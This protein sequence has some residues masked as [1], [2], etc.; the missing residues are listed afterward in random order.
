MVDPRDL[1]MWSMWSATSERCPGRGVAA[2]SPIDRPRTPSGRRGRVPSAP[3]SLGSAGHRPAR[4]RGRRSPAELD[5]HDAAV[6]GQSLE[7]VVGDVAG[8]GRQARAPRVAGDD[9]GL[10][11]PEGV[12]HRLGA[13]RARCRRASPAGSSR[14]RP[15][16]RT[17][18]GPPCSAC[19]WRRRPR[20]GSCCGSASCTGRPG[21]EQ[22]A[23]RPGRPRSQAPLDADQRR[24]LARPSTIRST[25]SAVSRQFEVVGVALDHP[26]DQVD[27]LERRA[28][29]G[30]AVLA[31]G[32]R[33]TR[34]AP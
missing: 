25:S 2:S 9:R 4:P 18:R 8:D 1:A 14:G 20:R 3:H 13:R 24:D 21:V 32:C 6:R 15:A 27:L 28:C 12:G 17:G 33:P 10:R 16:R 34:T 31:R 30:V 5:H 29:R 11:D 22:R 26:V 23:A 19:R 7:D